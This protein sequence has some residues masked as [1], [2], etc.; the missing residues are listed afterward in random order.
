VNGIGVFVGDR[1]RKYLSTTTITYV[2]AA[3][4]IIA[5]ALVLIGSLLP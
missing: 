1:A 3:A 2:A 4:F 5:G